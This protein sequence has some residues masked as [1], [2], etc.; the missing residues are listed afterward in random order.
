VIFGENRSFDHYF[1]TYPV[2][3]NAAGELKF[4]AAAGTPAVNSF[5]T[6]LDPTAGFK[7][8]TGV[9]LVNANPNNNA[10][11]NGTGA[12]NPFRLGP[13]QAATQSMNHAYVAEQQAFDNNL[14]DLFPKYT[15]TPT[16]APGTP[17]NLQPN[18]SSTMA[19]FDGNTITALWNYAQNY[20]LNDNAWTTTFGPSTPGA[21][22]LISG[23]TNGFANSSPATL[24]A[25]HAVADG[26]GG[27]SLIG[28][29]DPI[30]D[31]C[32]NSSGDQ[33]SFKGKNIGDLL[34]AKKIS[35]G[36]FE[37]GFDLFVTNPNGT[38]A[39]GRK[40][41]PT[42]A[43]FQYNS[44][45]YIPHHEPFQ[46][47]AT[48][49]NLTHAR[50][51]S[52]TSIGNSLEDD[53]VTM[54][55][56]NHQY[57]SHDFFDALKAGN[58]PAVSYL[59]APAYQDGHGGY[60]DPIDEQAFIISV[61]NAVV[62]TQEWAT[63]AVVILY[64]DSDG[65]YDHQA[66]PIVN[67]SATAADAL[68]AAGVCN[69]GAQQTGPSPAMPLLGNDGNPAQGRCGYGTRIPLLVISPFSKKNYVDHTL[70]DQSSV[71]RFIED[72]WLGGQRIQTGGSF[73]TIAGPI[74][75]MFTFAVPD[76]GI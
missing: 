55:P 75:N 23:Q 58:F 16:M 11:N 28:D 51:S 44:V 63:T 59:K 74:S 12:A 9:D 53:K 40:T 5:S 1:G 47:Y 36:F 45:D 56:A 65:W 48:T 19:Y 26:N 46:Y 42:V 6:P 18:T 30:G 60:S 41:N 76:G 38:T 25:N 54:D 2:A 31:V 72:N 14:M 34:N 71:L 32:S 33:V 20:A 39:C 49:A 57:D 27:Y 70:V 35:W 69:T 24:A 4:T 8:V 62:E 22:N 21:I 3:M 29:A 52:V 50:P 15:G 7:P 73:D 10:T 67:R 61:M 66:P 37:G 68:N 64:D 43:N 17:P 13:T